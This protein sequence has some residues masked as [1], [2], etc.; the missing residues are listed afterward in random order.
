MLSVN[1]S[2]ENSKRNSHEPS[3]SPTINSDQHMGRL[4]PSSL[5][6]SPLQIIITSSSSL[7]ILHL[8]LSVAFF[9]GHVLLSV[10]HCF[11]SDSLLGW[12]GKDIS[13]E[14]LLSNFEGNIQ[15]DQTRYA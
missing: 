11:K 9:S 1:L 3:P 14:R 6:A 8:I 2:R 13:Q 7:V 10:N 5:L 12:L 4:R 15:I